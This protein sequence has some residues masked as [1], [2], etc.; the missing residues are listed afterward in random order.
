MVVK[1]QETLITDSGNIYD[2]SISGGRVG[3]I[4]FKQDSAIWSNLRVRCD[5]TVN[6]ALQFNG[7]DDAV[8]IGSIQESVLDMIERSAAL[9]HLSH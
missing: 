8:Q 6:R 2:T 1:Y 7:G 5:E 4:T 3:L 9:C